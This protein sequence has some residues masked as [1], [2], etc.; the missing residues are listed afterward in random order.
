MSIRLFTA[1]IIL[2]ALAAAASGQRKDRQ[3]AFTIDDLPVASSSDDIK[4][5]QKI[6]SDL[7]AKITAAGLPAIGFVNEAQLFK[8]GVRD[9]RQVNLLR[10]WLDAGLELGNHTFSHSS[11]GDASLAKFT[12]EL[13]KGE[14]VTKELLTAKGKEMQYFRHPYLHTGRTLNK[15]AEFDKVLAEHGYTI[16]P[17]T[18]DNSD[19]IFAAAYEKAYVKGDRKLMKRIGSAYVPYVERK[20][21]YWERQS[22]RLFRREIAQTI[23][24]HAN[25]LN[26]VYIGKIANMMKKR[27]YR[28]I[29]LSGALKDDA[30]RLPDKFTGEG[31]ISWLHRW[32]LDRG[33]RYVLSGEPMTP[34]FVLSA[35]GIKSE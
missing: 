13:L 22:M 2:L 32:A 14:V 24:L 3:I 20:M 26:S 31:G 9:E 5:R 6:T 30:Y 35:A 11:L 29:P 33:K 12:D 19:W 16:A 1:S 17:I 7:L 34:Q 27:G 15:K 21:A 28:F 10:K 25:L 18:M 8:E 4:F 23:L